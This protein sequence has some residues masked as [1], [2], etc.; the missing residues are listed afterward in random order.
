MKKG[1][2]FIVMLLLIATL[3]YA[4]NFT[5]DISTIRDQI[6]TDQSAQFLVTVYNEQ[7]KTIQVKAY[8]PQVEWTIP[9]SVLDVPGSSKKELKLVI[10]P[11]KY[12]N[13]G[14]HQININVKDLYTGELVETP[15]LIDLRP[16]GEAISTYLPSIDVE[17]SMPEKIDPNNEVLV[18][19]NLENQNLLNLSNITLRIRSDLENLNTE[20]TVSL[21]SLGRKI[22]ELTYRLS[23]IEKPGVYVVYFDIL[24]NNKVISTAEPKNIEIIIV[25]K[26]FAEET[27]E[28]KSFLKTTTANIYTSDSNVIHTQTIKISTN[29]FKELFS[30]TEPKSDNVISE[31]SKRYYIYDVKLDPGQSIIIFVNTNYRILLYASIVIIIGLILYLKYK[32]PVNIRKNISNFSMKEGGLSKIKIMLEIKSTAKKPIKKITIVD[33]VPNIADVS[34]EFTEGTVKPTKI[35]QHSTKGTILKWEFDEIDPGEDRLIS[36]NITSK[37]S[38]IGNFKLPR[39]KV[40]FK[41]NKKEVHVFSNSLGVSAQ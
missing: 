10:T 18:S 8:S 40:V 41:R 34:K 14:T 5:V 4:Q 13:P 27:E 32:S 22:V 16:P 7:P 37:L 28:T 3:A 39:A 29:R 38:I 24:K 11:T 26:D 25:E 23:P 1:L 35:L 19:V 21:D 15:I 2:L 33:Y 12:T 9:T 36:Y 6:N 17:A 20:E 30:N 31:N